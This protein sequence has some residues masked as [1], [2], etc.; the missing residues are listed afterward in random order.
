MLSE[1][2]ADEN[3]QLSRAEWTGPEAAFRQLDTNADGE[4]DAAE[5]QQVL[6]PLARSTPT[7]SC[8]TIRA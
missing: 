7:S 6:K 3:E 8:R 5:M 4:L 2:D 1:R